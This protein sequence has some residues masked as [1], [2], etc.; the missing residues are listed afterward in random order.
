M[1][2]RRDREQDKEAQT[3]WVGGGRN[4]AEPKEEVAEVLECRRRRIG[5]YVAT[6]RICG[7]YRGRWRIVR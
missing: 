4:E 6:V 1:S 3:D 7:R 2:R 5:L